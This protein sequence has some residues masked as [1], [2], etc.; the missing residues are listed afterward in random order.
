MYLG[1]LLTTNL[2]AFERQVTFWSLEQ[3]DVF[4]RWVTGLM[5]SF[6]QMEVV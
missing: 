4:G 1:G 3:A 6:G 5:L 2:C